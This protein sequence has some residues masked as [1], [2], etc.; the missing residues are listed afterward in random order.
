VKIR[1]KLDGE[2]VTAKTDQN[3]QLNREKQGQKRSEKRDAVVKPDQKGANDPRRD[4]R[5]L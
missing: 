5:R 3:Q 1:V 2:K 4:Y